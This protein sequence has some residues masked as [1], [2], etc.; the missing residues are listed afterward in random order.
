MNNN[1]D[2]FDRTPHKIVRRE[3]IH[4]LCARQEHFLAT[5]YPGPVGRNFIRKLKRDRPNL[6]ISLVN[7][8]SFRRDYP[9]DSIA[10]LVIKIRKDIFDVIQYH[11]AEVVDIDL[12]GGLPASAVKAIEL[13]PNWKRMLLTFSRTWR[14]R[15]LPGALQHGEDPAMFM[16]LWGKRNGWRI[17]MAQLPY[18]RPSK[19]RIMG[20]EIMGIED[21][22]GPQYWTFLLER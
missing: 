3:I 8:Y 14:H 20:I 18:R 19:L 7:K 13:A 5:D 16:E 22:R 15:K 4:E 21:E 11:P 17:T 2:R 1:V 10:D 12:F 6:E 9:G